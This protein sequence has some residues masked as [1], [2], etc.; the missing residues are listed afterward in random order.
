MATFT[1]HLPPTPPGGRPAPEKI[2]F[3]RDGFSFPAF[4]LGPI[5]LLW[6][7]A[8]IPAVVWGVLLA[9]VAGGGALFKMPKETS[10]FAAFG[11]ALILGFEGNRILAWSLQRRGYAESDLVIGDNEN[12]AEE[13]YFGRLQAGAPLASPAESKS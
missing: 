5:W 12:E 4:L 1:V 11:L 13:V 10:S 6:R 8:W 3:L 2:V 7:R 9:L